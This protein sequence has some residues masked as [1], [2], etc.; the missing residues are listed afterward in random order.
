MANFEL[1]N[2]DVENWEQAQFWESDPMQNNQSLCD[3][4]L[5]I[6]WEQKTANVETQMRTN[7][8]AGEVWHGLAGEYS[9]PVDTDFTEFT[10]FYKDEIKPLLQKIGEGFESYWNGSNWKGS[11]SEDAHA[12][13]WDLQE[14]LNGAPT[15]DLIYSFD[16]LGSFEGKHHLVEY[17]GHDG[18]DFLKANLEDDDELQEIID[19]IE[20]GAVVIVNMDKNDYKNELI[21]IQRDLQEEDEEE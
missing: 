13:L 14:K 16:I 10:K 20:S 15:H 3:I 2:K 17:L 18:I 21:D 6:N 5:Y 11:F 9:L 19:S 12:L 8:T 4:I 1:N 7:S